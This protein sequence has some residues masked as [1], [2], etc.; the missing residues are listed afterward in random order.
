MLT[1]APTSVTLGASVTLTWTSSNANS[2]LGGGGQSGD[3]WD[4]SKPV[5]GTASVTPNA[6]GTIT[7]TLTCST[8]S[9]SSQAANVQ[10]VATT[11]PASGGGGSG[12]GGGGGAMDLMF[13]LSLLALWAITAR[14][15]ARF[16]PGHHTR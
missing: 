13:L 4:G 12:G 9:S 6:A 16:S 14:I 8:G 1:A 15:G 3:G 5:N 11:A 10:V 2:C 7:Y